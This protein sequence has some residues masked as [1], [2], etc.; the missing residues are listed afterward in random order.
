ME[1]YK[2]VSHRFATYMQMEMNEAAEEGY[3]LLDFFPPKTE[4]GLY[5]AVMVIEDD[6][7]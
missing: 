4:N 7:E 6:D 5:I 1:R 2:V 3:I